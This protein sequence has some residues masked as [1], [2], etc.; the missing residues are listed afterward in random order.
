LNRHVKLEQEQSTQFTIVVNATFSNAVK[1][2]SFIS[3]HPISTRPSSPT[4]VETGPEI[5][6][7]IPGKDF[8]SNQTFA[9]DD[10][11]FPQKASLRT[12]WGQ[13]AILLIIVL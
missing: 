1:L 6:F 13:R 7:R 11:F 5:K 2:Q 8:E 4:S 3:F 10:I 9:S 12:F